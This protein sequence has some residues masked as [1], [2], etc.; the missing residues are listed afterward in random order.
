ML[1]SGEITRAL[2]RVY[3]LTGAP[4][5]FT[6]DV[7]AVSKWAGESSAI[8]H[9]T[10]AW[11]LGLRDVDDVVDVT[12]DR[13]LRPAAAKIVVHRKT[14]LPTRDVSTIRGI[15]VTTM[16][17]TLVDLAA[18]CPEED[19]DIALDTAI[20]T[21]MR[22]RDFMARLEDLAVPRRRGSGLLRRLV[23][24]RVAEQGLTESPFERRLVRA[25]RMGAGPGPRQRTCQSRMAGSVGDVAPTQV[26]PGRGRE[27]HPPFA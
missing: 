25:G 1:A 9:R 24:E 27:A 4:R 19:V 15:P 16:P 2:P 12:T 21:G 3:R 26:P 23:A 10:A 20:R 14:R 17:R 5:S 6:Q 13:C 8:S 7:V 22:R 18:V 11:L